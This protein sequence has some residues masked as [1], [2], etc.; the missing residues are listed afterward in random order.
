V[1]FRMLLKAISDFIS[2]SCFG[3]QHAC[4]RNHP[5]SIIHGLNEPTAN[6]HNDDSIGPPNELHDIDGS[7]GLVANKHFGN[8]LFEFDSNRVQKPLHL[9]K[10]P[11]GVCF[12]D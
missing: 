12:K 7:N 2:P 4:P 11:S 8:S 6:Q 10:L 3:Y 1:A 5:L 9:V